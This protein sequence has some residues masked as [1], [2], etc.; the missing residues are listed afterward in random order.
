MPERRIFASKAIISESCTYFKTGKPSLPSSDSS[1]REG[2][3]YAASCSRPP[4]AFSAETEA[5]APTI[6]IDT[7]E[8]GTLITEDKDNTAV[9]DEDDMGSL[10]TRK[11]NKSSSPS[12][13]SVKGG[14]Q[15]PNVTVND[16]TD[17]GS[18]LRE[19]NE[20]DARPETSMRDRRE[21]AGGSGAEKDGTDAADLREKKRR[22]IRG[23][24]TAQ[25]ATKGI[26]RRMWRFDIDE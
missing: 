19:L 12:P 22:K 18:G 16:E 11:R 14:V 23:T 21:E 7:L 24:E 1:I 17:S 9:L 13:V 5:S 3:T 2:V 15:D 6:L 20:I 26:L 4:S 25:A 10:D 8:P